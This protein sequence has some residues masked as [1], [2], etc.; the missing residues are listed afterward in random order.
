MNE[1]NFTK[2]F[3]I[4]GLVQGVFYRVSTK[5]KTKELGVTGWVRNLHDGTVEVLASG[6]A[7]QLES[8]EQWLWQGPEAAKVEAV[9]VTE[10][11]WE[12]HDSFESQH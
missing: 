3:R 11:D 5:E 8:L 4:K 10:R 1:T 7:A 12:Q 2:H 6:T 9:E